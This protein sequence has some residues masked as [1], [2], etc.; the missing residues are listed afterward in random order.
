MCASLDHLQGGSMPDAERANLSFCVN[1]G[2]RTHVD[3]MRNGRT[4]R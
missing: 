2:Q 3:C 1:S 4:T